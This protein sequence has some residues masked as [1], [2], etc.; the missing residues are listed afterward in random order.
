MKRKQ[1]L[2]LIIALFIIILCFNKYYIDRGVEV[3]LP[4]LILD[5]KEYFDTTDFL[6][7]AYILNVFNSW[8]EACKAEHKTWMLLKNKIRLYG[9]SYVDNIKKARKFLDDDGNPY[10]KIGFDKRG[11]VSEVLNITA[12]PTSFVIDKSGN[13]KLRIVGEITVDRF[14]K[15]VSALYDTL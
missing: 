4:P 1:L 6:G 5:Q 10:I 14:N 12:L 11:I 7:E 13:V 15:E 3:Y 8:C 9:V 2:Y